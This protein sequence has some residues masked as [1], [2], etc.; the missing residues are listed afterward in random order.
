MALVVIVGSNNSGKSCRIC[1]CKIKLKLHKT[2]SVQETLPF[3]F[4]KGRSLLV[5]EASLWFL[6]PRMH[7]TKVRVLFDAAQARHRYVSTSRATRA[8]YM[9]VWVGVK[10]EMIGGLFRTICQV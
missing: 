3:S 1:V 6:L 5:R 2:H 8:S 10:I 4:E 9:I 7:F